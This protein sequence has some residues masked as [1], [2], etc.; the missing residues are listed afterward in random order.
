[1]VRTWYLVSEILQ[2]FPAV[3]QKVCVCSCVSF[4]YS[5]LGSQMVCHQ[6]LPFSPFFPTSQKVEMLS[7]GAAWAGGSL[8]IVGPDPG[9]GRAGPCR[10]GSSHHP[11]R[12][13]D[14]R[15]APPWGQVGTSAH[16]WTCLG[17]A[18]GWA[19]QGCR[20]LETEVLQHLGG[21]LRPG[22]A[23]MGSWAIGW[24]G[25]ALGVGRNISTLR[26][27]TPSLFEKE[28]SNQNKNSLFAEK[29]NVVAV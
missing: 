23:G 4:Q 27:R 22:G 20:G 24:V 12:E 26:A 19:G 28:S 16:G 8:G 10:Q 6:T 11:A 25:E 14:S 15:Q 18:H 13:R 17:E 9:T 1:M 3:L 7:Q 5:G 29:N 21:G 2:W